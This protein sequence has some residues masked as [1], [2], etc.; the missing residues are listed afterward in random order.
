M[1][2]L[3]LD[4]YRCYHPASLQGEAMSDVV[5]PI[6]SGLVVATVSGM[7]WVA[8]NKPK[9][10]WSLYKAYFAVMACGTLI[11]IGYSAGFSRA[12][13]VLSASDK[14]ADAVATIT[15][16]LNTL[17][18][19]YLYVLIFTCISVFFLSFPRWLRKDED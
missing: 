3:A 2:T 7:A 10:Y 1:T 8:Y 19:I 11:Y 6:L 14:S 13:R 12:I 17:Q 4:L 9:S 5:G 15:N 18:E 16:E